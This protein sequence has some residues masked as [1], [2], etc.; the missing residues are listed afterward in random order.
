MHKNIET[1]L[2]NNHETPSEKSKI[3]VMP[4]KR[5]PRSTKNATVTHSTKTLL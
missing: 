2:R 3:P 1:A 4:E 5:R